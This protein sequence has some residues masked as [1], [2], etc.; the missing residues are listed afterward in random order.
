MSLWR[1]LGKVDEDDTFTLDLPEQARY[2]RPAMGE[3]LAIVKGACPKAAFCERRLRPV[4]GLQATG[5]GFTVRPNTQHVK[6]LREGLWSLALVG[7]AFLI[8]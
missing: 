3:I 4:G 6:P 8:R 7:V 2:L 1:L 5:E